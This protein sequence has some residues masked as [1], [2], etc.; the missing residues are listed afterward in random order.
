MIKR[1][2]QLDP[3][4][5]WTVFSAFGM[6]VAM[7]ITL[8]VGA[9][10][11][12]IALPD[13]AS[14]LVMMAGWSIGMALTAFAMLNLRRRTADDVMALAIGET[15]SKLPIIFVFS[16]GMAG[17]LDLASWIASGDKTLAAAELLNFDSTI[18]FSGWVI[19]VL[20]M[21]VLQPLAEELVFR[22]LLFPALRF[23]T[24]TWAGW[25][26]CA[27]FYAAFHLLAYLP[28]DAGQ[29][30]FFWYGLTLP[31]LI[32]LVISGVRAITGSTR[33]AIVA[34]AAFGLFAVFKVWILTTG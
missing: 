6:M 21:G 5:P 20:F 26:M 18:V 30:L 2:K 27:A 16:L 22:G 11:A 10:L 33:A 32:G 29:T 31:F 1:F 34:H 14:A 13:S 3:E 28:Q 8:V 12:Q 25:V 17:V 24:G 4:P 23:S 7:F 19:A 15:S 9:A